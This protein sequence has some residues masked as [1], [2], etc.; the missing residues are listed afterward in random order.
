MTTST[1]FLVL[2][3]GAPALAILWAIALSIRINRCDPGTERMQKIALQ[4]RI[5]AMAFLKT[6]YRY[7]AGFVVIVGALLWVFLPDHGPSTAQAFVA[8][9]LAS[10]LAGWVGMRTAT[11]AAVR[12]THAAKTSLSSALGVAFSSGAVMGLTVVALGTMGITALYWAF[13]GLGEDTVVG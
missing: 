2:G 13:G 7:M 4:I 5:G 11:N 8:G 9:A 12:T 10:A 3:F 1:L 6:E